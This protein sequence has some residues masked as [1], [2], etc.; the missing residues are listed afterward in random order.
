MGM[1]VDRLPAGR[2]PAA[3]IEIHGQAAALASIAADLEENGAVLQSTK[4]S[5]NYCRG[6]L[7]AWEI[8]CQLNLKNNG[9]YGVH[10]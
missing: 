2:R 9:V 6:L 8:G 7:P 3:R 4:C 5:V 10:F 1:N